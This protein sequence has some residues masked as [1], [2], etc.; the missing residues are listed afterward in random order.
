M[1]QPESS[2]ENGFSGNWNVDTISHSSLPRQFSQGR[3]RNPP[4]IHTVRFTR[5]FPINS[6]STPVTALNLYREA[7]KAQWQAARAKRLHAK[8]ERVYV[9]VKAAANRFHLQPFWK[10]TRHAHSSPGWCHRLYVYIF[11][12]TDRHNFHAQNCRGEFKLACQG[13]NS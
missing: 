13:R 9:C 10:C 8:E 12:S 5:Q 6:S 1:N 7:M 2:C 4:P 11:I 3:A